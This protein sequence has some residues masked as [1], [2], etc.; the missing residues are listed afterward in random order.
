MVKLWYQVASTDATWANVAIRYT[1]TADMALSEVIEAQGC[2]CKHVDGFYNCLGLLG[3][4]R[5]ASGMCAARCLVRLSALGVASSLTWG[6]K[7]HSRNS[8]PR[9]GLSHYSSII[10][11]T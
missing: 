5:S 1:Y 7:L 3:V 8:P 10:A 11:T 6:N 4:G 2:S 9:H